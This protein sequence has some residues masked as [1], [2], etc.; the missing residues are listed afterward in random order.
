MPAEGT[1]ACNPLETVDNFTCEF[2]YRLET[3]EVFTDQDCTSGDVT[4]TRTSGSYCYQATAF[5][6]GIP[7][8]IVNGS[9]L[10]SPGKLYVSIVEPYTNAITMGRMLIQ[11]S[12]LL[13]Y[14]LKPLANDKCSYI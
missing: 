7:I 13:I 6:N 12:K 5:R 14:K 1:V 10:I 3:C 9:F 2:C 4:L 11:N 8:A